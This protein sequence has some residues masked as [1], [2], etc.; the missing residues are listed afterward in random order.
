M[1]RLKW[2]GRPI[3]KIAAV[4]VSFPR[5]GKAR[6]GV[7]L[8][9]FPH[10]E[11]LETAQRTGSAL[12]PYIPGLL[13]FREIPVLLKAFGALRS[14]PECILCDGQGIAHPRRMGLA[15]HLGILLEIPTIGCA[16]S[17]LI[18]SFQ[19][20]PPNRG[21]FSPLLD[22][23]GETLGAVLRTRAQVKPLF[24][25]PGHLIDLEKAVELVLACSPK[26]RIPE[27]LRLA[28]R[29]AGGERI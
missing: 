10:L 21:A 24:V 2:P 16:K 8:L 26:F 7:V 11:I 12:F 4:D 18:G 25:S 13:S 23:Q 6:A 9:R 3:R 14:R 28:H 27:P 19:E 1:I 22:D 5:K 20:P 15:S 29:L 17:R